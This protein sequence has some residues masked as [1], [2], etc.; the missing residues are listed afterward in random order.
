MENNSHITWQHL[1]QKLETHNILLSR[2][3]KES[4]ES[5]NDKFDYIL[6]QLLHPLIVRSS[7]YTYGSPI[8]ELLNDA[9][10]VTYSILYNN[11]IDP[12]IIKLQ[13]IT[14]YLSNNQFI[15]TI[16]HHAYYDVR[17]IFIVN[18]VNFTI[19]IGS[20]KNAI[21]F[22]HTATSNDSYLGTSLCHNKVASY[23]FVNT[24]HYP[25]PKQELLT[26]NTNLSKIKLPCVIKPID[27]H[28]GKDVIVD[29]NT[30]D[31]LQTEATNFL[32]KYSAGIVQDQVFGTDYRLVVINGELDFVVMR[33]Y[34]SIIGD[35]SSTIK[36]LIEEKN[37]HLIDFSSSHGLSSAIIINMQ[38][39][40]LLLLQGYTLESIPDNNQK[41]ILS[42]VANITQGGTRKEIPLD[43]IHPEVKQMVENIATSS[44]TYTLGIDI[45]SKDISKSLI[46]GETYVIELNTNPEFIQQ[47]A[48]NYYEKLTK[49][50]NIEI[51]FEELDLSNDLK[52]GYHIVVS[53][54]REDVIK[55]AIQLGYKSRL[56]IYDHM[57]Q[58]LLNPKIEK[59]YLV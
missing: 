24:L 51:H 22:S 58:V 38:L 10:D 36:Q 20:G 9:I 30:L 23:Q 18:P 29:I 44:R 56:I 2:L 7:E 13:S 17:P 40:S 54:D 6:E 34:P 1:Q 14:N 59:A 11:T 12:K 47:R 43:A 3:N 53:K 39:L 15:L 37:N 55:R 52:D 25:Q 28:K 49:N 48:I 19:Q 27:G 46:E 57:N 31:Q 50:K 5:T 26:R 45:I 4:Y 42:R 21:W 41:I 8:K 35:G 16:I 32:K 33:E